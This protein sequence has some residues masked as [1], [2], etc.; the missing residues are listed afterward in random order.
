M[1]NEPNYTNPS[2]DRDSTIWILIGVGLIAVGFFFGARTLGILP[3]PV[4]TMFRVL[5]QARTGIGI[6]LVGIALIVWARSDRRFS[7]PAR[8]AKLYRSRDDKWLGGVLGGLAQYFGV[9]ST[10]LRLAFIGLVVLL[11]VGG[12][13]VAYII[14]SIVVPQEPAAPGPDSVIR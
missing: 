2:D 10:L 3:W 1:T 4:E 6:V 12:L 14:M 9:D 13:V 8:G 5:T 11:D 7:A